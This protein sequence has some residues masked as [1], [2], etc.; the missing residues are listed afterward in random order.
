VH[1]GSRARNERGLPRDRIKSG[2]RI[3]RS[4]GYR[5][6]PTHKS[7]SLI[8]SIDGRFNGCDMTIP[9]RDRSIA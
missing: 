8:W 5:Q 9:L 6:V 4:D 1:L 3:Q 7:L 2:P